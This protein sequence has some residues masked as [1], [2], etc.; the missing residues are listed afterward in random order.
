VLGE[1]EDEE[2]GL[3]G[4]SNGWVLERWWYKLAHVCQRWRKLILGSSSYLGVCLVCS[5]GTPVADMLAHSPPLPLVVDYF[6]G[7]EYSDI[8]A[9]DE[10]GLTL[11]LE[12]RDR[13]RRIRLRMGITNLQ[14][15]IT[16]ISG[17]YPILTYLIIISFVKNTAFVLPGTL[18]APHLCHLLLSCFALPI[19]SPLL[20]TA[21]G[22]VTLFLEIANPATCFQPNALLRWISFMPQLETL[23]IYFSSPIPGR[24]M[25]RL[26]SPTP[27]IKPV[28]LPNLRWF[29][30][31][32]CSAYL[33]AVV[34]WI[35]TPRL[36]RPQI[37]FFEQLTFSVPQLVQ[38]MNTTE[39]LR[40]NAV[41]VDF[42]REQVDT[43]TSF[44][45]NAEI[46]LYMRVIC[47]HLDR[48]ASSMAQIFNFFSQTFSAV[49][50]L[51]LSG[52]ERS[53][54]SEEHNEVDRTEWHKLLRSFHNVKILRIEY[55]LVKEI[56]R[57]LRP[58]DG[59]LPS[60]LFPELQELTYSGSG[61]ADDV[62]TSFI[63][64]RR[65]ADRPITLVRRRISLDTSSSI[66][67]YETASSSSVSRNNLDT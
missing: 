3:H 52:E 14:K 65:T 41:A 51:T 43:A 28:T 10:E 58:D 16:T 33:E 64:A 27:I 45:G 31:Q 56:S 32:G 13:V 11:A 38:L 5:E 26:L 48:Q 36:E 18:Q 46:Y 2:Y 20:T 35:T 15:F 34:R 49:E 30:F 6:R 25:D 17:E 67:S 53:H 40:F 55:G 66:S 22:L 19:R 1:D 63:D 61:D 42:S 47:P 8:A 23:V 9:E 54:S 57:C 21:T 24:D 50:E 60:D 7:P 12:Q 4:G 39:N 29:W 59:D 62:F 37:F 44:P